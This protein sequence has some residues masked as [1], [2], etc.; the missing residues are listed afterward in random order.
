MTILEVVNKYARPG[1]AVA[2]VGCRRG[3]SARQWL[4]V[5]E[6]NKGKVYLIDNFKES[7][8]NSIIKSVSGCKC[9]TVVNGWD[10]DIPDRSLDICF[11][12]MDDRRQFLFHSK[13]RGGGA[14]CGKTG[15]HHLGW[16]ED[17]KNPVIFML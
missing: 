13:V 16:I 4:P 7:E 8:I 10:G 1:M 6:R 17:V 15:Y 5:V 2:E 9:V 3:A 14:F 11:I 12:D